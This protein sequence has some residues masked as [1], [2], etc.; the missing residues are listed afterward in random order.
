[1]ENFFFNINFMVDFS[2]IILIMLPSN[3]PKIHPIFLMIILLIYTILICLKIGSTLNNFWFSYILFLITIGG[4]MI[5]I[6][7]LTSM[8]NNELMIFSLLN[9]KWVIYKMFIISLFFTMSYI[10]FS[11]KIIYNLYNLEIMNFYIFNN[12][13]IMKNLYMM[14]NLDLTIF[15]MIY[16]F[17]MMMLSTL[18][19]KKFNIPMRQNIF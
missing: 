11:K 6:M 14:P 9:I 2:M 8:S 17:L 16:L 3:M 4:I 12:N 1:M 7:Y 15:L 5:L 18:I 13:I 10:F 19:C